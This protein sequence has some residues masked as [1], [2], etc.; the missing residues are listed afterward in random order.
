[1]KQASN[2]SVQL[3]DVFAADA[4]AAADDFH[5]TCDFSF[6]TWL[7]LSYSQSE[8][9]REKCS[10][11]SSSLSTVIRPP[12]RPNHFLRQSQS[13]AGSGL[14]L[15]ARIVAAEELFEHPRHFS[16]RNAYTRVLD[17]DLDVLVA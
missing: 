15:N 9:S 12:W 14:F 13:Q 16:L 1:M 11:C 10:L 17:A 3:G 6:R 8:A 7:H 5:R 4:I 2:I